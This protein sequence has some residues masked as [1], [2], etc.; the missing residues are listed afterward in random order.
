MIY[1]VQALSSLGVA[2]YFSW[3]MALVVLASLPVTA[4]ALVV[5]SRRLSW[6]ILG[7]DAAMNKA[8]R[9]STTAFTNIFTVKCF[10]AQAMEC[11]EYT[12]ALKNA[13]GFYVSQA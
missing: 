7:Q 5:I 11:R 6:H 2:F 9:I 13:A 12:T 10:N 3:K 1:F 4:I 8:T